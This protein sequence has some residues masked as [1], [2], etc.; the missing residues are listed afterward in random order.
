MS[1]DFSCDHCGKSFVKEH[2]LLVH[3][4][5]KKN[6]FLNKDELHV[7]IGFHAYKKFYEIRYPGKKIPEYKDFM[8]SKFYI[9]FIKFGKYVINTNVINREQFIEFLEDYFPDKSSF[10]NEKYN[11]W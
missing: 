4:C 10:E 1:N 11:K 3:A 8:N 2:T 9:A 7:R 6:R 5:E